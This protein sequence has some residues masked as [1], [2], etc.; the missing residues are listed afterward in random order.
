MPPI[1]DE[2]EHIARENAREDAEAGRDYDP[3]ADDGDEED[4]VGS[5]VP[6]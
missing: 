6:N 4:P 2:L 1:D 5:N 3:D